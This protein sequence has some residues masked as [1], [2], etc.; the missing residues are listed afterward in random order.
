[1]ALIAFDGTGNEDK[2]GEDK[3]TNVLRFF[4]V[5][6]KLTDM[7]DPARDDWSP[8][9]PRSLDPSGIGRPY[10][11]GRRQGGRGLRARRSQPH[12]QGAGPDGTQPRG[13]RPHRRRDWVQPRR[14]A[15]CRVC[16]RSR[17]AVPDGAEPA[18]SASGIL[19]AEFGAPGKAV[20]LGY[21]LT[22]PA[23]SSS[24]IAATPWPGRDAGWHPT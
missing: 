18:S 22:M 16:Q 15:G 1:M 7:V 14:R 23:N 3:D 21:K 9:I 24:T 17:P 11:F 5:Y 13:R 12:P 20:N 2:P 19:V 4:C 6:A 8:A 10:T